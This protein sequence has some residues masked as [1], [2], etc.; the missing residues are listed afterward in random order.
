M[1]GHSCGII[2]NKLRTAMEGIQLHQGLSFVSL[3]KKLDE[4]R[5]THRSKGE[6]FWKEQHS[7]YGAGFGLLSLSKRTT[8]MEGTAT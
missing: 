8:E 6:Q 7:K 4:Y 3:A 2:L 5:K 1:D